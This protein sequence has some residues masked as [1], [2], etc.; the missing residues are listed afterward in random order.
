M[1]LAVNRPEI[2]RIFFP[3]GLQ[4]IIYAVW[5]ATGGEHVEEGS[6]ALIFAVSLTLPILSHSGMR[7]KVD[8]SKKYVRKSI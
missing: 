1:D 8:I 6:F 4:F 5:Y 3:S 2:T 7:E